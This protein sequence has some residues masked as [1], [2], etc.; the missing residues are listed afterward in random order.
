MGLAQRVRRR[1]EGAGDNARLQNIEMPF[2][3]K[4]ALVGGFSMIIKA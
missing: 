3:G 4:R 1:H 2:N